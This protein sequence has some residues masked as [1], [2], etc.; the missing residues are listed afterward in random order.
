MTLF[1]TML[2][3]HLLG[4]WLLQTEWQALN[5]THNWRALLSHVAVYHLVVLAA[6]LLRLGPAHLPIYP[7]VGLLALSH[8]IIDR[9]WPVLWWMRWARLSVGAAPL[10]WLVI[11][12][13]QA[14]HLLLLGVA[15]LLLA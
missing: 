10:P 8:A 13:D 12:N 2:M 7:V 9:R 5:K 6:L 14:L 11:A 1:E 3:A 15:A 4:D